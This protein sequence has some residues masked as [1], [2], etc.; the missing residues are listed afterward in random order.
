MFAF[1]DAFDVL[2]T[3]EGKINDE[4]LR[5]QKVFKNDI[6]YPLRKLVTA[7][8][9]IHL[10]DIYIYISYIPG[11]S[12]LPDIYARCPRARRAKKYSCKVNS[13]NVKIC[14]HQNLYTRRY[15]CM[16]TLHSCE[17]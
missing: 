8:S 16:F 3:E 5:V 7:C 14:H 2:L 13:V 15:V 12:A 1:S 6:V 10:R 9:Y 11:T 17:C 4:E